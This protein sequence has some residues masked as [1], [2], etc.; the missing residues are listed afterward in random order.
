M[1]TSSYSSL[2]YHHAALPVSQRER[3]SPIN[4]TSSVSW[5]CLLKAC[6]GLDLSWHARSKPGMTPDFPLPRLVRILSMPGWVLPQESL[7]RVVCL[8]VCLFKRGLLPNG[9]KV[10]ALWAVTSFPS[11]PDVLPELRILST[12]F[13]PCLISTEQGLHFWWIMWQFLIRMDGEQRPGLDFCADVILLQVSHS[14]AAYWLSN[15]SQ[16]D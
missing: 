13:L 12:W 1:K 6:L 5:D 9:K 15:H 7:Q 16:D 14:G 2:E 3:H 10:G 4:T 8:F 11:S